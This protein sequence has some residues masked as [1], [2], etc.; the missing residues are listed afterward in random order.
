MYRKKSGQRK[1]SQVLRKAM[2]MLT[3]ALLAVMVSGAVAFAQS[4]GGGGNTGGGLVSP[5]AVNTG[6]SGTTAIGRG[7]D[8]I[9][10]V[11]SLLGNLYT[12]SPTR[13]DGVRTE[14]ANGDVILN[15][16]PQGSSA[17][18]AQLAD[19]ANLTPDPA[20]DVPTAFAR[21]SRGPRDSDPAGLRFTSF[22][23]DAIVPATFGA[24]G[25]PAQNVDNLSR[26]QLRGIFVTCKIKNFNQI[27][28][29]NAP[30]NVYGIQENSG[31]KATFDQFLGGDTNS[32][33]SSPDN[34]IFENSANPI[35]SIDQADRERAIF[36]FSFARLSTSVPN[37][38]IKPLSVNGVE[39]N[40]DTIRNKS[41][42]FTRDVYF[43]TLLNNRSADDAAADRFVNWVCKPNSAHSKDPISGDNYG[44][45][46][47]DTIKASGFGVKPCANT[48]T[49]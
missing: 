2:L 36:Y 35:S 43:V 34:I 26:S 29:A 39:A 28:G 22:A 14:N 38:D 4:R 41:F 25:G 16:P 13:E 1:E 20:P 21:S 37:S 23:R 15:A 18:I 27:G 17:G 10:Q 9:Y 3:L 49:N 24:K 40:A 32:C 44:K 8:T 33:V 45:V 47:D 7:S 6:P 31:T 11:S 46:I 12:F 42:P 5:R 48:I 30:I 19:A